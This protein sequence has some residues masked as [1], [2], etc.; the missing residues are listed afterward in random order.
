MTNPAPGLALAVVG[1]PGERRM[2]K[3]KTTKARPAKS[4]RRA[5]GTANRKAARR[6]APRKAAPAAR[7]VKK[8]R[9]KTRRKGWALATSRGTVAVRKNPGAV[10]RIARGG[11]RVKRV[12]AGLV[13]GIVGD[14]KGLLPAIT[15]GLKKN[16]VKA[17]LAVGGG[18]VAT[19]ALSGFALP[20]V[21]RF[22]PNASPV[23]AR[24]LSSGTHAL[25]ALGGSRVI[26]DT[27][28][29]RMVMAGGL[30]AAVLELAVP[31]LSTHL[32]RKVPVI[33][34]LI[35]AP[36]P[37]ELAARPAVRG[38]GVGDLSDLADITD[39]DDLGYTAEDLG[40]I[41]ANDPAEA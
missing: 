18:F 29:R 6:A 21:A 16:P 8:A 39:G 22:V 1:N 36:V 9:R 14:A 26:K 5:T 37:G 10:A 4:K 41:E 35:P 24:L 15:G 20:V 38:G 28:T 27:D 3:R 40:F 12:A 30:A 23:T 25:V 33:G 34:R 17:V 7:P 19:S 13:S 32:V 31:G 2:K 11:R